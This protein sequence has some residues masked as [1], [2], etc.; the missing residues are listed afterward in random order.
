MKSEDADVRMRLHA[1]EHLKMLGELHDHLAAEHLRGGC[2]F[3]GERVP[4]INP[5]R[6]I[7]KPRSMRHLL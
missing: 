6:G 4:L 7:F 5:Q 3:E 2:I 1:F